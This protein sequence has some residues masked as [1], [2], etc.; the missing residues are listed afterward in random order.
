[1][2]AL[3]FEKEKRAFSP[4]LTLARFKDQHGLLS[5]TQEVQ[6]LSGSAF[7]DMAVNHFSLY[8]SILRPL[9]AEYHTIESFHLVE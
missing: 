7:G 6:A 1:M 3:G 9:G 4:H 5:L 8:E 2:A